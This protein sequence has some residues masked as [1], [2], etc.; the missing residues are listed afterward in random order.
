MIIE[1]GPAFWLAV[2]LTVIIVFILVRSV[3]ATKRL[4]NKYKDH[5]KK[6][7]DIEEVRRFLDEEPK[8]SV[9]VVES[10]LKDKIKVLWVS[11]RGNIGVSV[12]MDAASME[13]LKV[14]EH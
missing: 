7:M 2:I 9:I 13:V 10:P 4:I 14:D 3:L 11:R 8:A 5:I 12:V 1:I 6:T